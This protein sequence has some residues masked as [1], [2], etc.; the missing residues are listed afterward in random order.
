MD[1]EFQT[2]RTLI[3]SRAE[4]IAAADA[5]Y[6]MAQHALCIFDPDLEMLGLN[7]AERIER[8]QSF[9]QRGQENL[10]RIALHDPSKVL[11]AHPRLV[12]LM[13][14]FAPRVPIYGTAGVALRAQDCFILA[15]AK[16]FVRRA[17]AQQ[18]R[19]VYALYDKSEGRLLHERFEEIWAAS[20]EAVSPSTLGL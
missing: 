1:N 5:L 20:A 6:G 2:Q 19:G 12:E 15:D 13:R 16:H 7:S 18:A 10:L 17:V 11:R 3:G 4:Y 8:L 9:L 14:R